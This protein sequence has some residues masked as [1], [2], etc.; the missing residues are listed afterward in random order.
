[1]MVLRFLRIIQ[2]R[3]LRHVAGVLFAVF[4]YGHLC[5]GLAA[6]S[7]VTILLDSPFKAS[8]AFFIVAQEKGYFA[9]EGL[10]VTLETGVSSA[11]TIKNLGSNA[12]DIGFADIN[13]LIRLREQIPSPHAKAVMILHDKST[14]VLVGRKSRGMNGALSTFQ[15]RLVGGAAKDPAYEHWPVF[16]AL[17]QEEKEGEPR[18]LQIH[19]EPVSAAIREPMLIQGELDAVLGSAPSVISILR[20][21]N[22]P[23]DEMTTII[24]SDYGLKLYGHALIASP[25]MMDKKPE[26]IGKVIK[27]LVASVQDVIKDPQGAITLVQNRGQN[28]R[29]DIENDRLGLLLKDFVITP[30]VRANGIG[31]VEEI[32]FHEALDQLNRAQA[33][34]SRPNTQDIF[35]RAYLPPVEERQLR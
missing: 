30:H 10:N 21:R 9:R 16:Q 11:E 5:S 3:L 29:A 31:D 15:G 8:S 13:T 22:V 2:M 14:Y 7:A 26:L 23:I 24:M 4:I 20:A 6:Q 18:S 17:Y 25:E 33:F 19:L 28:I 32:R 1:M 34:K 27:A 12:Y 35:T